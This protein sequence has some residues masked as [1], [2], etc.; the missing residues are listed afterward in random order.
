M[1]RAGVDLAVSLLL[2]GQA[3]GEVSM[4]APA[5]DNVD[6]PTVAAD[7][8]APSATMDDP[9]KNFPLLAA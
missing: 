6:V 7:L 4:T 8:S 5:G 3:P 2:R 9:G 1:S